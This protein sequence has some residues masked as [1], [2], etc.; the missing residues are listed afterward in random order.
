MSSHHPDV[1]ASSLI[2]ELQRFYY[3]TPTSY[4]ELIQ[5]YKDLLGNKR[6]AVSVDDVT[7]LQ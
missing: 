2:R 1:I 4:L 7:L 3:A 6:K 5:T